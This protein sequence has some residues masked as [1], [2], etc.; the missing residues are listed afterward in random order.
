MK[1][2]QKKRT[3]SIQE[4]MKLLYDLSEINTVQ[5]KL[6]VFYLENYLFNTFKKY[7]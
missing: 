7:L 6:F 2:N 4:P 1:T 5:P 3:I